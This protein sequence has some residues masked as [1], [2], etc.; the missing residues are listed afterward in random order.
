MI[1]FVLKLRLKQIFVDS[2]NGLALGIRYLMLV[3]SFV[4]GVLYGYLLTKLDEKT[5]LTDEKILK[6]EVFFMLAFVASYIIKNYFPQYKGSTRFISIVYPVNA[7]KRAFVH[8]LN[9]IISSLLIGFTIFFAVFYSFAKPLSFLAVP[10]MMI[11]AFTWIIT[12]RNIRRL[13]DF[14]V[15]K[16]LV[17]L[18]L[19]VLTIAALV[20]LA[21]LQF[22]G[23]L[24]F[25][26]AEAQFIFS[27]LF[28]L[29]FF[30]TVWIDTSIIDPREHFQAQEFSKEYGSLVPYFL[31][32]TWKQNKTRVALMVAFGTKLFL[33]TIG[34]F[35]GKGK[36]IMV[37]YQYM[38]F[39]PILITSQIFANTFGF[40][41]QFWLADCLFSKDRT[42]MQKV[43]ILVIGGIIGV[44]FILSGILMLLGYSLSWNLVLYYL[45]SIPT[46]IQL[47]LY[48]S[49]K[50]PFYVEKAI[51]TANSNNTSPL[52]GLLIMGII[53]VLGILTSYNLLIW[54][55]P[56]I[57]YLNYRYSTTWDSKRDKLWPTMYDKLFKG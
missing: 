42:Q 3:F 18:G 12:E 21:F 37:I 23:Q 15:S 29:S 32:V 44:D 4:Y 46:T 49:H 11:A 40:F 19:L 24:F 43:L 53:L 2:S 41:R 51:S 1:S 33:L 31:L 47:A 52:I 20:Y 27:L 17:H 30:H 54:F 10:A 39:S 13:L 45:I 38:I 35:L 6:I 36:E 55:V 8:L 50:Y 22:K 56:V 48:S 25:I 7:I 26:S 57:L 14:N 5:P 16:Q 9:D 34:L 28:C